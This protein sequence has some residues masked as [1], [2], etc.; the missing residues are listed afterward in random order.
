MK[1]RKFLQLSALSSASSLLLNGHNV[2]AFSE[3]ALL[4]NIPEEVIDGR[5]LVMVQMF[6]GNDGLNTVIPKDQYD[7]YASLRP[8]IKL[9]NTGPNAAIDLDNTMS[10]DKQVMIHPSLTGFKSLYDAGKLNIIQSVGYPIVNKS[11]FAAR[12]LM[13][14]GGDGTPE[15]VNKPNG[16]MARFLHSGYDHTKY[17][18]PLGI[19]LGSKKPSIGFHSE[20][21]HKVDVNLSGQDP[22]DYYSVIS[23]IGNPAPDVAT[24][25]EYAD[26]IDFITGIETSAN[27]YSGRISSVFDAGNNSNVT[28][29]NEDLANQLKT[30]AR[31]IKGGS[32]TKIFLVLIGGFD[33]HAGQVQSGSSHLGQHADLL[34]TVGDSIKA[35]QDDIEALGVA[36]KVVTATFTEFGR[37]PREN[38][39]L[40]TDHGNLGPM[41]VIGKHVQ[42][43][44]TGNNMDLSNIVKHFDETKMQHDYR[45]VFSTL[46]S[47]FLGATPSVIEGTEFTP[48][49]GENKLALIQDAHSVASTDINAIQE[50]SMFVAPNPVY[51][52]CVLKYTASNM[53]RG[54]IVIYGMN[55]GQAF[56][57]PHDFTPGMNHIPLNIEHLTSGTYITAIKDSYGKTMGTFQLIKQ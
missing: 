7:D 6:G 30:V 52:T 2:R 48:F 10:S 46:L 35:F 47:D 24:A 9:N 1:R 17:A 33:N 42:G 32:K 43:G 16:W 31:M 37:K 20:H 3:T 36:E 14:K 54:H 49:D 11:H 8:T 51:D 44:V 53:F 29:P 15:N 13:F 50:S 41:F 39:N 25:S 38:G 56:H 45:Q 5:T 4:N 21:E 57:L 18:D 28:Y 19:Q 26:N 34:K 27:N 23:N 22:S 55:G 12:A 40:G